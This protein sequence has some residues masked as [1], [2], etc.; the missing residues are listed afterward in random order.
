MHS[1]VDELNNQLYFS[2]VELERLDK[3]QKLY[4]QDSLDDES[5]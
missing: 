4:D 1:S 5:K 3:L 2:Q